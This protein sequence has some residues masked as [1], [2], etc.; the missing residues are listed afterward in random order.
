MHEFLRRVYPYY[1]I[2]IWS[3]TAWNWV[4]IKL[5]ELNMLMNAD[6]KISFALDT[7]RMFRVV[8][9]VKGKP[10]KHKVKALALIWAKFPQCKLRHML[11]DRVGLTRFE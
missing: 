1:D 10:K 3:Q 4:E 7:T 8:G 9:M 11:S 2:V 6:Y 5:T